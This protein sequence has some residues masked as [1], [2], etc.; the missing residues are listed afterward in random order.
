M[1]TGRLKEDEP[2]STSWTIAFAAADPVSFLASF[3]QA[4]S[5]WEEVLGHPCDYN[6]TRVHVSLAKTV[7]A[8]CDFFS[9]NVSLAAF[10]KSLNIAPHRSLDAHT[11]PHKFAPSQLLRLVSCFPNLR[12]LR[13][14]DVYFD[15]DSNIPR[16][17]HAMR[18]PALQRLWVSFEDLPLYQ[19]PEDVISAFTLFPEVDSVMIDSFHIKDLTHMPCP[20]VMQCRPKSISIQH[21]IGAV[22]ILEYLTNKA[23]I[24]QLADL[25]TLKM[26]LVPGMLASFRRFMDHVRSQ[27][28]TLELNF[29]AR[30]DCTYRV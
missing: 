17:S 3:L 13:L 27:L 21:A 18:L 5:K 8:A 30:P 11:Y 1:T 20:T 14:E 23:N 10:V 25:H 9:V 16:N 29:R 4:N 19:A 12:E 24:G 2:G 22:P 26:T 28:H 6:S 15:L 7:A